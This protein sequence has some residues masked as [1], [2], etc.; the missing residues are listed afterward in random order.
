MAR[1]KKP[2]PSERCSKARPETS[3]WGSGPGGVSPTPSTNIPGRTRPALRR[4]LAWSGPPDTGNFANPVRTRYVYAPGGWHLLAEL[5]DAGTVRRR[6]VWGQARAEGPWES[7]RQRWPEEAHLVRLM[8][9]G[10]R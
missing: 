3:S 8:D 2:P 9:Q 6:Y 7:V 5:D 4:W 1:A 10:G